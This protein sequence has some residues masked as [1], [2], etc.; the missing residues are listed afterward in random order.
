MGGPAV[1]FQWI[2]P[3]ALTTA[4]VFGPLFSLLPTRGKPSVLLR[5]YAIAAVLPWVALILILR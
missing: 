2:A 1:S 5:G 3:V 4:L